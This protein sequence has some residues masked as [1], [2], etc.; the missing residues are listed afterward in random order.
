MHSFQQHARRR[1]RACCVR[2]AC[3]LGRQI[4]MSGA[5]PKSKR[6]GPPKLLLLLLACA[7]G[8]SLYL[9]SATS[10]RALQADGE[11]SAVTTLAAA[12]EA[13]HDGAAAYSYDE[14]ARLVTFVRQDQLNEARNFLS[15]LREARMLPNLLAVALDAPSALLLQEYRVTM[16][17]LPSSDL[18]RNTT[19]SAAAYSSLLN[20]A[21]WRLL[22]ALARRGQRVWYCDVQTLWLRPHQ[23]ELPTGC[24]AAFVVG[25][26]AAASVLS[27][28]QSSERAGAHLEVGAPSAALSAYRSDADVASWLDRLAK[29]SAAAAA[30][31]I[32]ARDEAAALADEFARCTGNGERGSAPCPRMCLLAESAFPNGL[33]AFQQPAEQPKEEEEAGRAEGREAKSAS[34]PVA[35]VADWPPPPRLEYRLREAGLWR[36]PGPWQPVRRQPLQPRPQ[37]QSVT[38]PGRDT[39]PRNGG[40]VEGERFVA[41]KELLINNG[42]SNARNALRSALAIAQVTNRTLILPPFWARHLRGMPNR[43]GADYYFDIVRLRQYFPRVRESSLLA[44]RFP[45]AAHWPPLPPTR[46]FFIQL[47]DD[48]KLCEEVTDSQ[49]LEALGN[50]NETCPPLRLPSAQLV[51]R[52]ARRYHLGMDESE[53]RSWLAPYSREPL[54]YFGRAFRRFGR[55]S[56]AADEAAFRQRYAAG[57]QPAPEIRV[58]AERALQSLRAAAAVRAAAGKSAHG[59]RRAEG[60]DCVH[61]RRRDFIADHAEEVGVEQY[62]AKAAAKLRRRGSNGRGGV[63][64]RPVY[65]AS[66]VADEPATLAAFRRHFG[67][68]NLFTLQSLFPPELLD[69]FSSTRALSKVSD[70]AARSAAFGREMRFGNVDQL[71]C[72]RADRF[73]GNK[74]S[75][76]THHVC[77][78]REARGVTKACAASDIYGREV[79]KAMAY[80]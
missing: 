30:V 42:L 21:R 8:W 66:D 7:S 32:G 47:S 4:F 76:F 74:W 40:E 23:L 26:P 69:A 9:L 64:A 62:A 15:L 39:H 22:A 50:V 28:A 11:G 10:D 71:V 19:S 14:G 34:S 12:E 36:V 58:A 53:L 59:G 75:S 65:L 60:F 73:L 51:A 38:G 68:G 78:L 16:H 2:L 3:V 35:I 6:R 48:E 41:F 13:P 67:A 46:L 17:T 54:L 20:A 44:Q 72:A 31:G 27:G 55:F 24:D 80:V 25:S 77:Y 29:A 70:S 56:K 57:V 61:M 33:S 43:V 18:L 37:Q 1:P 79:D 49:R 45:A 63:A 5:K 52:R